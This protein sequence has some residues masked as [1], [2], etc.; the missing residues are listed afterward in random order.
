M[1]HI[2]VQEWIDTGGLS[3]SAASTE[4]VRE[5]HRRF[6]E[7]LPDDL[8]WVE[9]SATGKRIRVVPGELRKNDLQVGRH[10]AI[11]PGAVPRFMAR[12]AEVHGRLGKAESILA[13]AAAH[14]RLAWIHTF[15]DGNGR[16]ARLMSHATLL[17]T[18]DSGAIWSV[19]RGLARSADS[20]KAHLADCDLPRR[21]D[22]DRRD[23]Q[24]SPR[25]RLIFE[26][27]MLRGELP[28]ADVDVI[29]GATDRHARRIVSD[30]TAI[31]VLE[32][33]GPT[34]PLRLAFPAALAPR[35]MPGLFPEQA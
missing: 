9:F 16:V 11:G 22:L 29:V 30:M 1:A 27:L 5:I 32:S 7:R 21:N 2:A 23:N 3:A 19:A 15:V 18:L 4:G 14:H 35:W 28:R 10:V 13:T 12:F 24:L 31:G 26:A 17:E 25:A 6:F 34:A 33:D 8:L 20:Y